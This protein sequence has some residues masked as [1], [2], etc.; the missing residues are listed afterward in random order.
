MAS[1]I[2]GDIPEDNGS[3]EIRPCSVINCQLPTDVV[4][5]SCDGVRYGAHAVNLETYSGGFPIAASTDIDQEAVRMQEKS[6][7]LCLLLQYM[8]NERQ[9][10]SS[11][12][13]FEVLAPLSEAVEKYMVFSAMEVCKIRMQ[14]AIPNH[15]L[16]VLAYAVKHGY[17]ELSKAAAP[18]TLPISLSSVTKTLKDRP[19]I[20][21][22]WVQYREHWLD[23]LKFIYEIP[24][25][26]NL[27]RGGLEECEKWG[28]FHRNVIL[29]VRADVRNVQKFRDIVGREENVVEDCS[30]CRAR[31]H[32]W[33]LSFANQIAKLPVFDAGV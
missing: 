14:E 30:H 24:P 7:V 17:P 27:H 21:L 8:H 10:D 16:E 31:V 5:E 25:I 11:K 13:E 19:D 20:I 1:S 23:I 22:R 26:A 2:F 3:A 4:L 15:P 9:P 29:E 12:I 32:K 28:D 6:S 33:K 18:L